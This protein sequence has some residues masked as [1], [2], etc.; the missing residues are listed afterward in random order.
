MSIDT[1]SNEPTDDLVLGWRVGRD[2]GTEWW[3]HAGTRVQV[4]PPPHVLETVERDAVAMHTAIVAQSGSGKSF[5]LG[6]YLEE[7]LLKTR[8]RVT[9]FDPNADF[10]QIATTDVNV[11]PVNGKVGDPPTDWVTTGNKRHPLTHEATPQEFAEPWSEIKVVVMG[12]KPKGEDKS[13][14]QD[15]A[16]HWPRLTP[17]FLL[18]GDGAVRDRG[19]VIALHEL[20]QAG[21]ELWQLLAAKSSPGPGSKGVQVLTVPEW[22]KPPMN[23]RK[24]GDEK[25]SQTLAENL[26]E[27]IQKRLNY[28]EPNPPDHQI[29]QATSEFMRAFMMAAKVDTS[30]H[31]AYVK[32]Y[33]HYQGRGLLVEDDE[34]MKTACGLHDDTDIRVLDMPSFRE[35]EDRDRAVL[36]L[37][38][39]IWNMAR[40]AWQAA[41]RDKLANSSRV[42]HLIVMDEAHNLVPAER[43]D[44]P[45]RAEIRDR[46]KT[47]AGEGRKYGLFLVIVT[48]R[49]DKLDPQVL[50]ECGN[51]AIMLM[52]SILVLEDCRKLLAVE[53][54]P[55]EQAII[56]EKFCSGFARLSGKW[57]T[58]PRIIFAAARRTVASGADLV[59]REWSQPRERVKKRIKLVRSRPGPAAGGDPGSPPTPPTTSGP[60]PKPAG[61]PPSVFP[62]AAQDSEPKITSHSDT[63]AVPPPKS[64]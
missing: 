25:N 22:L 45:V 28:K 8:A 33:D 35:T 21:H 1:P 59:A 6:R 54:G 15:M 23:A 24:A 61:G 31:E 2:L 46:I 20:V 64:S 52:R 57:A 5:F 42:P 13:P 10:R 16:F 9:V 53:L 7:V 40:S 55:E 32:L 44:S 38:D 3:D 27:D 49:P 48:Q 56:K 19:G 37:L 47:I 50:G 4:P 17:H 11:W 30:T 62:P 36:F 41:T 34:K 14:I 58:P 26:V 18:V 12:Q 60:S 39:M 29:A 51:Q 63:P 43:P